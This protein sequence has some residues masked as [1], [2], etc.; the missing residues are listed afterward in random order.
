M[1]VLIPRH[2]SVKTWVWCH[3]V[4]NVGASRPS[5]TGVLTQTWLIQVGSLNGATDLELHCALQL[6][7]SPW[8]RLE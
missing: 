3:N 8:R 6:G 2:R 5:E 4:G 1:T 7:F